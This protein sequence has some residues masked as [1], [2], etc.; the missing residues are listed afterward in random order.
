MSQISK[1]KKRRGSDAKLRSLLRQTDYF[2]DI[3]SITITLILLHHSSQIV[4]I[5]ARNS[6]EHSRGNNYVRWKK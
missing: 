3:E 2:V 6:V 4:I 5:P 1:S